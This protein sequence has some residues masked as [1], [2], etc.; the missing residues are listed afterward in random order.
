M[1]DKIIRFVLAF[2]VFVLCLGSIRFTNGITTTLETGMPIEAQ[3]QLKA[4]FG[5]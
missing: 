1:R 3:E 4:L 5:H 2:L